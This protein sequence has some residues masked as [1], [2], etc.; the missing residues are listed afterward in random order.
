MVD[1]AAELCVNNEDHTASEHIMMAEILVNH[2]FLLFFRALYYLLRCSSHLFPRIELRHYHLDILEGHLSPV[3][4]R[5]EFLHEYFPVFGEDIQRLALIERLSIP[6]K[7]LLD[8]LPG[9]EV[10]ALQIAR[11]LHQVAGWNNW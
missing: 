6:A 7:C 3:V 9:V 8:R 11:I 5:Y 2:C 4:D 1:D 10:N